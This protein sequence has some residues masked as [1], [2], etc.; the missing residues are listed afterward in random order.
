MIISVMEKLIDF[1]PVEHQRLLIVPLLYAKAS[2]YFKDIAPTQSLLSKT[3]DGDRLALQKDIF[4]LFDLTEMEE[5]QTISFFDSGNRLYAVIKKTDGTTRFVDI[6]TQ[7][8]LHFE[9]SPIVE[10][11]CQR[12]GLESSERLTSCSTAV[13]ESS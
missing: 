7:L 12:L 1:T 6:L 10:H 2:K 4:W 13:S 11:V 5:P 9:A 8:Y 3:N